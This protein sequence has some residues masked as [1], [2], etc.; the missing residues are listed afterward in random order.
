MSPSN[1]RAGGNK[2]GWSRLPGASLTVTGHRLDGTAPPLKA[3]IPCCYSEGFQASGLTFPTEGCWEIVAK[4]NGSELRVVV[5]VAPN[6]RFPV[7]GQTACDTPAELIHNTDVIVIGSVDE[8]ETDE[9]TYAWQTLRVQDFWKKPWAGPGFDAFD[10][11]QN[12]PAEPKLQPGHTYLIFM[13]NYEPWQMFCPQRS[14]IEV[15]GEQAIPMSRR[16]L[17][18]STRLKDLQA[19]IDQLLAKAQ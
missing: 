2:V 14:I 15:K 13:Q 3:S 4:S 9:R 1:L 8:T 7:K 12:L 10:L 6:E 17:W 19:E 11:L 18:S 5:Q 16:P